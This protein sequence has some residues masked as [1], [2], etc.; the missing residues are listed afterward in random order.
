MDDWEK[1]KTVSA[2]RN[3]TELKEDHEDETNSY[4]NQ[5]DGNN[6]QA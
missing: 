6:D 5:E 3:R 1:Q 4:S 2:D